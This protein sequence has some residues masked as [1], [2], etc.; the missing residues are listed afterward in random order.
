MQRTRFALAGLF[1]AALGLSAC[2]GP[3]DE[4]RP[5]PDLN[6]VFLVVDSL[7]ADHLGLYGYAAPTTPFLD[8]LG[9]DSVVFE[10]AYAP[11][12]YTSQ[13]VAALLTGRLPTSGGAIGLLE[14][15]PSEEAA[16]LGRVF[17]GGGFRTAIVSNQPLLKARG[18]TRGFE[19]IQVSDLNAA[20]T[21]EDV[22]RRAL[23]FVDDY[24]GEQFF[25]FAH[26]LEP[27]QPYSPPQPFG[28]RFGATAGSTTADIDA[29]TAEV[30]AGI[31]LD[32][33][34]PRVRQ[35]VAN[36]DGEIAYVDSAI[37]ELVEGLESRGVL[38]RTLIIVTGSQGEEFLEHNYLGHAWT[39]HE[40]VL[41][42]PL[43]VRAPGLLPP[44]RNPGAV[45]G[46][47]IFPS[48]VELFRLDVGDWQ[49]DG[50][51]FLRDSAEGVAVRVP[52]AAKMAELVIRE[53]CILR[54]VIQDNWKY[55]SEPLSCPPEQR[56]TIAGA[57]G[58]RIGATEKPDLWAE[59][60]RES[61]YNLADDPAETTNLAARTPAEQLASMRQVLSGYE[62]YC[63]A[64]ALAA[65]EAVAP[66]EFDEEAAER[67]RSLGY[68]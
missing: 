36:Y 6:V 10:R 56:N 25:L 40:E 15:A 53:R 65:R 35:L 24:P 8:K 41:R 17:R 61:L 26:Y 5:P 13:S 48:L 43:L 22:T 38:D 16:T 60:E 39:L 30:E 52:R 57:Y 63:E 37:G 4:G 64:N 11:S 2:S 50:S 19:D 3:A 20:W 44:G 68:L 47:D 58:E 29:L 55:I 67:L 14:A 62:A 34:D 42:V 31:A 18:F 1:A 23:R 49:V 27:H 9:E 45:S 51:S 32:P 7:R 33:Q 66:A 28:E 21:A 12:S 54:A 46:V 59:A